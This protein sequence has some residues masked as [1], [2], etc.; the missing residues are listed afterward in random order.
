MKRVYKVLLVALFA[1]MFSCEKDELVVNYEENNH[2][3]EVDKTNKLNMIRAMVAPATKVD[4]EG[5]TIKWRAGDSLN[6]VEFINDSYN[7][8]VLIFKI[9]DNSISSDGKSADFYS[10]STLV[11]G[12]SYYALSGGN[13]NHFDSGFEI[14]YRIK[15]PQTASDN[16]DHLEGS[17]VL[18]SPLFSVDN[19]TIPY[20]TFKNTQSIINL[21]IKLKDGVEGSYEIEDVVFSSTAECFSQFGYI[22]SPDTVTESE[23][24]LLQSMLNISG[25]A[26]VSSSQNYIAKLPIAWNGS[27][28]EV[29]GDFKITVRMRDGNIAEKTIP[30]RVLADGKFYNLS[31]EIES[32]IDGQKDS[33]HERDALMALYNATDGANWA[34]NTNWGTEI[35][36]WNWHGVNVD[37]VRNRVVGLDL[38]YNQLSGSIPTEI[39]NL[40]NL[41]YLNISR[42]QLSGSIPTEIGNLSSLEFL[43]L[44]DNQLSGS[45]PAEIGNLNNLML[46]FLYNNHLS[47]SIP[48][49]IGRLVNLWSLNLEENQLSGSIPAEIGNL[50]KTNSIHLQY[51]QLSGSIPAELANIPNVYIILYGNRLSGTIPTEVI[52]HKN[53]DYWGLNPQQDGYGFSDP[54]ELERVA[55]MAL[56][57]ATDGANWTNSTNWGSD[58]PLDEWHGVELNTDGRVVELDL[59]GLGLSGSIPAEIGDLVH[60]IELNL[61]YNRLSGSIPT[62]IGSLVNLSLLNLSGNQLS[63]AIPTC[64]GNLVNLQNLSS[65]HNQFSGSIP[66]EI[67]SLVNLSLLNISSNQLSGSIP[68]EIG[69][70]A[71][72]Q[73]L[74]LNNNQLSGSI[75]AE[76]GNLANLQNLIL[77]TNQLSG[78]I[79]A[80]IGSLAN[81]Q[82]MS[83]SNNQLSGTIPAEI[84]NLTNLQNLSFS[85]NQLSGSVPD[86]IINHKN[87]ANW[88]LNPQ[89]DGYGFDNI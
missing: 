41:E 3:S 84:G 73:N 30:A 45:I 9:D 13:N 82:S 88:T 79:P 23:H 81:L 22:Y 61:S 16:A 28:T 52:N 62:E 67:G 46:L 1:F 50:V 59:M 34:N 5:A 33:Q 15:Q 86:N 56:Y 55:L 66:T 77:Y 35:P 47:G 44:S 74:Y 7:E 49:E 36:I 6:V 4:I 70:L 87:Y 38:E 24:A 14:N 26:T 17:W 37:P 83:L 53:Y 27:A 20:L 43:Y 76:M 42:N 85:N 19:G 2:T 54:A 71:N 12:A 68:A 57:N 69:N 32:L 25:D 80:E 65:S 40:T 48:A 78:S 72:L 58:R 10:D 63:G 11:F 64:I 29:T 39:G 51:N 21:D 8:R 75:P 31:F 60:L 89:Q 18:I